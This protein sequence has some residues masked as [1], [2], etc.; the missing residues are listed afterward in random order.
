MHS[1]SLNGRG[2]I[3]P[4]PRTR[5][6]PARCFGHEGRTPSGPLASLAALALKCALSHLI[7]D[8][9]SGG[10]DVGCSYATI[11]HVECTAKALE[12]A[13]LTAARAI[14]IIWRT[15]FAL[16]QPKPTWTKGAN[17]GSDVQAHE[18]PSRSQHFPCRVRQYS[19]VR[20][21]A[22]AGRRSETVR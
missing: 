1:P 3:H 22:D 8:H 6:R 16:L 15:V 19:T 9:V 14:L 5:T 17:R 4:N 18:A 2:A 10:R 7:C 21:S 20:S 12:E 11:H 13:I